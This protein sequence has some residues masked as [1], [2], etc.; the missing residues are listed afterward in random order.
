MSSTTR[1]GLA[2][3][4]VAVAPLP[5]DSSLAPRRRSGPRRAAKLVRAARRPL[6]WPGLARGVVAAVE[7]E[8][9]GFAHNFATVIDVGANRGQFALVAKRRFPEAQ[10]WCF[11]PLSGARHVLQRLLR[12]PREGRVLACAL[13]DTAGEAELHIARS[14]DSSSLLPIGER[15]TAAFPGTDEV[16]TIRVRTARL[17]DVLAAEDLRR[18]TLLKIDV[19]GAELSVLTGAAE[20]LG[21]VDEIFVE[22]SFVEFYHGQPLA[23]EIIEH[24]QAEGFRLSGVF[25][26]SYA[27]T[28]A[29][30]Q[31]DLLFVR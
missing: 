8:S 2:E 22:C 16:G 5:R 18:P 11:E 12:E 13:S 19:Q 6:Y 30:L 21:S 25:S 15:Q 28:G 29:C 1:S 17:A 3:P 7:H 9:V 31:A 10:L 27:A 23:D 26:P 20:I 4:A 14:D 24:L